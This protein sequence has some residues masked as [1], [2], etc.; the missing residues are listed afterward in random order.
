[1]LLLGEGQVMSW[2]LF[3]LVSRLLPAF[4]LCRMKNFCAWLATCV[5]V[6]VFT[7]HLEMFL[8]SPFPYLLSPSKN[9]LHHKPVMRAL[10]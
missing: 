9:N 2:M 6:L 3:L 7:A 5:G 4:W 10:G 1:M 8:Q